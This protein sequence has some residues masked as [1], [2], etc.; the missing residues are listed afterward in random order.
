MRIGAEGR[1][2]VENDSLPDALGY[3]TGDPATAA[4]ARGVEDNGCPHQGSG[5]P[6]REDRGR[7]DGDN[8]RSMCNIAVGHV[9]CSEWA[10]GDEA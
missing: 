4:P 1:S 2:A 10:S 6:G 9:S 5:G 3:N 8:G 7:A